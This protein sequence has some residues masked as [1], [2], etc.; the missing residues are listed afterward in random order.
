[1][2]G[3]GHLGGDVQAGNGAVDMVEVGTDDAQ[4]LPPGGFCTADPDEDDFVCSI[5]F[6]QGAAAFMDQDDAAAPVGAFGNQRAGADDEAGDDAAGEDVVAILEGEGVGPVAGVGFCFAE[7]VGDEELLVGFEVEAKFEF[8]HHVDDEQLF[9]AGITAGVE[10][11]VE[12][13]A[14][15]HAFVFGHQGVVVEDLVD[16]V[17]DP[18]GIEDVGVFEAEVVAEVEDDAQVVEEADQG[19]LAGFVVDPE[20]RLSSVYLSSFAR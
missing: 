18:D 12:H 19:V 2:A 13:G 6:D 10:D 15:Q 20:E 1:M 7:Q 3:Q 11:A 9:V 17:G 8:A 16:A 5:G 4:Q 14:L